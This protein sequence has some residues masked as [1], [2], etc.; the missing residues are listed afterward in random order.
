[1]LCH[2]QISGCCWGRWLTRRSYAAVNIDSGGHPS[3]VGGGE[4]ANG[5]ARLSGIAADRIGQRCGQ[6]GRFGGRQGGG[7]L[8]ECP[9]GA[10]FGAEF[11]VP[12]PFRSVEINFKLPALGDHEI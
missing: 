10:R 6:Q 12:T 1:M 2:P 5:W 7:R 8:A 4:S 3:R 11:S 9:A